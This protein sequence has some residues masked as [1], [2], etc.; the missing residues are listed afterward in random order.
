M[1][2]CTCICS[3]LGLGTIYHDITCSLSRYYMCLYETQIPFTIKSIVVN[4]INININIIIII[5][6]SLTIDCVCKFKGRQH[7]PRPMEELG[8]SQKGH[9][10][11]PIWRCICTRTEIYTHLNM[12]NYVERLYNYV[13]CVQK[14]VLHIFNHMYVYVV[15][16]VYVSVSVYATAHVDGD[17]CWYVYSIGMLWCLSVCICTGFCICMCTCMCVCASVWYW[18]S[19]SA[20]SKEINWQ[21]SK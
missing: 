20:S 4:V 2:T 17:G 10:Q 19:A 3:R 15:V 13:K 14:C 6:N 12:C 7:H 8:T 5:I 21:F 1:S 18:G 11:K 9:T 16:H